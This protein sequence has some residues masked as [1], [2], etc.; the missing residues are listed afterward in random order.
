MVVHVSKTVEG[1]KIQHLLEKHRFSVQIHNLVS[2]IM[3][4]KRFWIFLPPTT[5]ETCPTTPKTCALNSTTLN[6]PTT[7]LVRPQNVFSYLYSVSFAKLF[8]KASFSHQKLYFGLKYWLFSRDFEFSCLLQVWKRLLP[9]QKHVRWIQQ[10]QIDLQLTWFYLKTWFRGYIYFSLQKL[11][12]IALTSFYAFD[13]L[14]P[15]KRKTSS[16][17]I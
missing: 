13:I 11:K 17:N 15:G 10:P 3:F 8:K 9:L 7:N 12:K 6:W 4:S 14:T 5:S 2:D 1:R 16:G